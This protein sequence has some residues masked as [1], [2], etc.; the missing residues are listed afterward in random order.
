MR[1]GPPGRVRT[2]PTVRA[3]DVHVVVGG[4]VVS[5]APELAR[6]TGNVAR[7]HHDASAGGAGSCTAATPSGWRCTRPSAR[8]P[9]CSPSSAGTAATTW[10]RS[11]RAT[12]SPARSRSSAPSRWPPVAAWS[13]CGPWYGRTAPARPTPA[14]RTLARPTPAR[15]PA[16]PMPARGAG[17]TTPAGHA[18]WAGAGSMDAGPMAPGRPRRDRRPRLALRR[19]AGLSGVRRDRGTPGEHVH[20]GGARG[21][22]PDPARGLRRRPAAADR[23]RAGRAARRQPADRTAGVPGPRRRGDGLPG[24]RAGDVRDPA[25]RGVPAPVRLDRRPDGAVGG[26]PDGGHGAAAAAGRRGRG[27]PAAAARRRR[28]QRDVPPLARRHAVLP[29]HGVR[30]A[31]GG[32]GARLGPGADR[33]PAPA[34]R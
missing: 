20:G 31:A 5:S 15:R 10:P 23:G 25:G 27:E 24:A 19:R 18:G 16:R 26:H 11:A 29:H 17:S 8:C 4:D 7:V 33:A 6:L 21:A 9:T 34:A 1:T 3:G 12:R 28:A 14:R 22:Q 2:S 32:R 13:T 30:A